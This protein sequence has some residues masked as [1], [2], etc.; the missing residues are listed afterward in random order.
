MSEEDKASIESR[1]TN[2]MK[3]ANMEIF[4]RRMTL[5]GFVDYA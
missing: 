4:S 3:V 2:A 1:I 5:V